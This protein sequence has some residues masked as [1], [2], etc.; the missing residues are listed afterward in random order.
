MYTDNR[1]RRAQTWPS[2]SWN[3]CGGQLSP[4][5]SLI[6]CDRLSNKYHNVH[7]TNKH[8]LLFHFFSSLQGDVNQPRVA[9]RAREW[10][11]ACPLSASR[12]RFPYQYVATGIFEHECKNQL[13]GEQ[14][15]SR[16]R[17]FLDSG[18]KV[19]PKLRKLD[20]ASQPPTPHPSLHH[21]HKIAFPG[22]QCFTCALH[23]GLRLSDKNVM[24]RLTTT[25]NTS[26]HSILS[27]DA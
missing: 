21:T 27:A 12:C 20:E 18:V 7:V 17:F 15:E 6:L 1:H 24:S 11:R 9:F 5:I 8:P 13:N 22:E 19:K 14:S 16:E 4:V 10:A 23:E 2:C 26:I 25:K 3:S